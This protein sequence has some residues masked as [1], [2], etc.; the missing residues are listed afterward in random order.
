MN[1]SVYVLFSLQY[2]YI[3]L[4]AKERAHFT[5]EVETPGMGHAR[6]MKVVFSD[7]SLPHVFFI[8]PL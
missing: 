1:A 6:S 4:A 5:P 2:Q 3:D 7:V 8:F